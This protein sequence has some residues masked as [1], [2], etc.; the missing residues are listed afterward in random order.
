MT[1]PSCGGIRMPSPRRGVVVRPSPRRPDRQ[2]RRHVRRRGADGATTNA[3]ARDRAERHRARASSPS[4]RVQTATAWAATAAEL[5]IDEEIAAAGSDRDRRAAP[6][7]RVGRA[8]RG[9]ARSSTRC[10]R[11]WRST[12][13]SG[14]WSCGRRRRRDGCCCSRPTEIARR[15]PL[16]PR[17]SATISWRARAAR[18]V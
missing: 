7:P 9:S 16:R 12:R 11:P 3:G 4:V 6:A 2:G 18:A 10:S 13:A 1:T 17:C 8:V 14:R 5:G 15:A